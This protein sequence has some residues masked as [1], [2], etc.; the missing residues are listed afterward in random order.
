[1]CFIQCKLLLHHSICC[2]CCRSIIYLP[3]VIPIPI[4]RPC[5]ISL[6]Q[7]SDANF[8]V[9]YP[10][11]IIDPSFYLLSWC[12]SMIH[13]SYHYTLYLIQMKDSSFHNFILLY[14]CC[15]SMFHSCCFYFW[16]KSIIKSIPPFIT[17]LICMPLSVVHI[18]I[19]H[20]MQCMYYDSH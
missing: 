11:Q 6:M 17:D 10:V 19:F 14:I 18:C 5:T 2:T 4:I 13:S 16:H 3:F 8:L 7:I 1:M 20:V 15:K 12:K 9:F